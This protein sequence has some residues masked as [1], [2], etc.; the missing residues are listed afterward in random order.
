MNG[1]RVFLA[2]LVMAGGCILSGCS[3]AAFW[4]SGWGGEDA[5]LVV[6]NDSPL[7]VGSISLEGAEHSRSLSDGQ[8]FALLERGES[9]GLKL[10]EG[11]EQVLVTLWDPE[12]RPLGS[13]WVEWDGQ[14]V[15]LTLD[16]AGKL[17]EEES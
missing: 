11:E 6:I 15:F 12:D 3:L 13:T 16:E 9:F 1:K 8:G 14:R 7:V 17:T 4:L 5:D 10:E 2:L